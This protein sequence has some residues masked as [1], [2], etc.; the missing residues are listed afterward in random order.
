M[1]TTNTA[2]SKRFSE[3][4]SGRMGIQNLCSLTALLS[5]FANCVIHVTFE[6]QTATRVS[7]I[8]VD[9]AKRCSGEVIYANC[10]LLSRSG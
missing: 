4:N 1:S 10:S 9:V 3:Q 6:E 8:D 7:G 5:D 2:E